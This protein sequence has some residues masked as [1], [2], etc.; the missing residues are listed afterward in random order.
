MV[1]MELMVQGVLMLLTQLQ[2]IQQTPEL[3]AKVLHREELQIQEQPERVLEVV[4]QE[5]QV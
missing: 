4:E 5:A 2:R 1:E 3:Q